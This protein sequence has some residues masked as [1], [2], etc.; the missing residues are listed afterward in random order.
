M[1]QIVICELKDWLKSQLACSGPAEATHIQ[2]QQK[3]R[4][5]QQSY[6][7]NGR[8]NLVIRKMRGC[9]WVTQ[10]QITQH[11]ELWNPIQ[12]FR[13]TVN[14]FRPLWENIASYNDWIAPAA[15]QA[16]SYYCYFLA[17]ITKQISTNV[18]NTTLQKKGVCSFNI[19]TLLFFNLH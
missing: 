3:K 8:R 16:W 9:V 13:G 17:V 18:R 15:T 5:S 4:L 14:L 7:Y 10:R 1:K 11:C 12:K 6:S 2:P 19:K